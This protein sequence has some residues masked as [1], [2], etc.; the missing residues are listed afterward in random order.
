MKAITY[1]Q[2]LGVIPPYDTWD[3]KMSIVTISEEMFC[4]EIEVDP[5]QAE[6][7]LEV[8]NDPLQ[9]DKRCKLAQYSITSD[10]PR[11]VNELTEVKDEDTLKGLI[12]ELL[13]LRLF[14]FNAVTGGG[15]EDIIDEPLF[16]KLY[17]QL[18]GLK[19]SD[20]FPSKS[21]ILQFYY[22]GTLTPVGEK[23]LRKYGIT[24][25]RGKTP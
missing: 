14:L 11:L 4:D 20:H 19:S 10:I 21:S 18:V 13:E 3:L 22:N 2:N 5:E 12:N 1:L 15:F 7:T 16:V 9:F 25:K 24:L 23:T 6:W 17:N 8:K